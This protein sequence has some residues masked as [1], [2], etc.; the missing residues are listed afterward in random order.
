[1]I[2][3][4]TISLLTVLV[5]GCMSDIVKQSTPSDI[6]YYL[7]DL[8]RYSL[9]KENTQSCHNLTTIVNG[10]QYAKPIEQAYGQKITGPNYRSSLLRMMLNPADGSYQAE[11]LADLT[12]KFK[13]PVNDKTNAVWDTMT[14]I[15]E[16][17]YNSKMY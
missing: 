10:T 6:D 12:H 3:A 7:V 8:K 9:C 17:F 1:M 2:R 14:N 11:A 13:L 15:H 5:S 4:L 16:H